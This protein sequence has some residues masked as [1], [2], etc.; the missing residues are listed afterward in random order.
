MKLLI[1]LV[2]L[3]SMEFCYAMEY[4]LPVKTIHPKE[5]DV[6]D[7]AAEI[8]FLRPLGFI[9]GIAGTAVFIGTLPLSLFASIAPPHDAIEKA[10]NALVIGPANATFKR[11]FAYY[12]YNPVGRYPEV[13]KY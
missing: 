2:F 3:L 9:G 12:H 11:P 1:S 5:Y 6:S 7:V 10:A 8:G 13:V 4:S